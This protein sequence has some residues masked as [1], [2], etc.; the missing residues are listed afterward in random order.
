MN[1]YYPKTG[2]L[3]LVPPHLVSGVATYVGYR[4]ELRRLEQKRQDPSVVSK[5]EEL[6]KRAGELHSRLIDMVNDFMKYQGYGVEF[7][8]KLTATFEQVEGIYYI[9]LEVFS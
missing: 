3:V 8:S 2:I 4:K 7:R 5:I 6:D 9:R 1:Q